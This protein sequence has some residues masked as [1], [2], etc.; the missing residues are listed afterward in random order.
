VLFRS[1]TFGLTLAKIIYPNEKW[2]VKK[3]FHHTTIVNKNE[4]L[5]FDILYFDENDEMK[6][7]K[8]A[9]SDAEKKEI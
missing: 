2:I 6:G 7:G 1:P 5:V 9:I 4:T 3:G 8:L